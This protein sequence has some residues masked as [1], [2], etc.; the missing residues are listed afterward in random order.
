M[1][2]DEMKQLR[3]KLTKEAIDDYQMATNGGTV[4]DLFK[5]GRC[6]KRN[7]TYTQVIVVTLISHPIIKLWR[8]MQKDADCFVFLLQLQTR[9]AD[10]PMTTFV[11][12]NDC[13]NRWKVK[14]YKLK[15]FL[16]NGNIIDLYII[17]CIEKELCECFMISLYK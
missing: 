3:E 6:G 7:C 11:V 10:E 1:A 2:S 13:G 14:I 15:F 16:P 9:S 12:C 8:R 17:M 4:T 5:C